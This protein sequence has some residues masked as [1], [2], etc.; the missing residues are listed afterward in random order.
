MKMVISVLKEKC[1]HLKE[2]SCYNSNYYKLPFIINE[3]TILHEKYNGAEDFCG[4]SIGTIV[5]G[6]YVPQLYLH[7]LNKDGVFMFDSASMSKRNE[8]T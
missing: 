6:V 8:W 7:S 4:N 3:C 2:I 5:K 1:E